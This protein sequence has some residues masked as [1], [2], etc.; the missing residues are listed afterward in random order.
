MTSRAVLGGYDGSKAHFAVHVVSR[1]DMTRGYA[2]LLVFPNEPVNY[3]AFPKKLQHGSCLYFTSRQSAI[4]YLVWKHSSPFRQFARP[5]TS[6]AEEH[7]RF[8][9]Q[10]TDQ[11]LCP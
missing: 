5:Q 2:A 8:D 9:W 3:A 7:I 4:W 11:W 1:F 10:G 6:P